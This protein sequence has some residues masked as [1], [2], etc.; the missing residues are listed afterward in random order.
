MGM[1][2]LLPRHSLAWHCHWW[3]L[4][5]QQIEPGFACNLGFEH[6]HWQPTRAQVGQESRLSLIISNHQL[7]ACDCWQKPE[8]G[9]ERPP[10]ACGCKQTSDQ[11]FPIV[12]VLHPS[13]WQMWDWRSLRV[14]DQYPPWTYPRHCLYNRDWDHTCQRSSRLSVFE[15]NHW[16]GKRTV[17]LCSARPF[18]Y[19]LW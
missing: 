8:K 13:G 7:D 12:H 1:Q 15:T 17:D 10:S 2:H 4:S 11:G 6:S 19:L 9:T 16:L 18:K 3:W 14:S 5:D